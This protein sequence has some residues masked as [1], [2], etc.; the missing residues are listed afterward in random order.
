MTDI[1]AVVDIAEMVIEEVLNTLIGG[2]EVR[3]QEPLFHF[4]VVLQKIVGD[5]EE[6]II[7]K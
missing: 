3:V 6:F 7:A 5:A 2:T 1:E 4:G